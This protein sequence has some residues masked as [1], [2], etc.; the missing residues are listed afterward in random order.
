MTIA[1]LQGL[2]SSLTGG[3]VLFVALY[4]LLRLPDFGRLA[5]Q[6]ARRLRHDEYRQGAKAPA[7]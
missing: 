1:E 6:A 4:G 2:V 5:A 3:L 7:P